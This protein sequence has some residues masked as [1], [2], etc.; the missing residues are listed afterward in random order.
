M[1]EA[2]LAATTIGKVEEAINEKKERLAADKGADCTS[3]SISW[4]VIKMR[5]VQTAVI[6]KNI[7]AV[8]ETPTASDSIVMYI[9]QYI[10]RF[11]S[12]HI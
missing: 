3:R 7:E 1:P 5:A 10:K 12:T 4:P 6:R 8:I 9:R 2:A 11:Y